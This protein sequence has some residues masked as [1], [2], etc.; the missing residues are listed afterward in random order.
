MCMSILYTYCFSLPSG[1]G[2]A[3]V[4]YPEAISKLPAPTVWAVLFFL[5]LFTLGL[6]S[7]F[8][9]LET[10]VTAIADQYPSMA[11]K[12]RWVLMLG[13]AVVMFFLALVCV[14]NVSA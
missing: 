8:T 2:L 1:F 13:V 3:F 4:A 5:M 6:D 7:Q 14:T 10:V 11:R 9:I 12:K